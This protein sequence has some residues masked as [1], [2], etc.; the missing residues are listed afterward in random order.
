MV[1]QIVVRRMPEPSLRGSF[2][3]ALSGLLLHFVALN[4]QHERSSG[5]EW[6]YLYDAVLSD[7]LSYG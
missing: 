3:F 1:R 6:Y 5:V 4:P 7:Q 2:R